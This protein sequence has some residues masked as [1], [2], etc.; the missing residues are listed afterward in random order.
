[1]FSGETPVATVLAHVQTPPV[2]PSARSEFPIPPA[3]DAAIL[4]CLAKEPSDRPATASVLD[5]RLAEAMP[6]AEA[7]TPEAARAWWDLHRVVVNPGEHPPTGTPAAGPRPP[8]MGRCW[9]KLT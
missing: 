1:M 5:R 3:L 4:E 6:A 9:P 2:P 7:W 8:A